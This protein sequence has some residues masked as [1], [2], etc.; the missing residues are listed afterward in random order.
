MGVD[1]EPEELPILEVLVVLL[2]L[3]RAQE[4]QPTV[5][6]IAAALHLVHHGMVHQLELVQAQHLLRKLLGRM[7]VAARVRQR[8]Y[9][10][11]LQ[12]L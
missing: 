5:V 3:V 7:Q 4:V 9:S 1:V 6:E 8:G 10:R 12:Q 11:L 2:V